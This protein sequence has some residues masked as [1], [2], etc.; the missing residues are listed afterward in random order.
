MGISNIM[1]NTNRDL[2]F[3]WVYQIL[4]LILIEIR[5]SHGYIKYYV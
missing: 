1:S 2:D 4:C 5:T 3:T